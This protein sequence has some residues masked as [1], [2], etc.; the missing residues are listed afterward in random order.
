[1]SLKQTALAEWLDKR[2]GLEKKIR[3]FFKVGDFYAV[4]GFLKQR[5]VGS[6][7]FVIPFADVDGLEIERLKDFILPAMFLLFASLLESKGLDTFNKDGIK[8]GFIVRDQEATD[9]FLV[10]II[11]YVEVG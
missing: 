4:P 1:M 10:E 5:V 11:S 8:W 3:A 9:S 7:S 6:D 2:Q